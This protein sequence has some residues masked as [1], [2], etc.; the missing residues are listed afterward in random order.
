MR[1]I[2]RAI[3]FLK[4]QSW[5]WKYHFV[6][7]DKNYTFWNKFHTFHKICISILIRRLKYYNNILKK[8][9]RQISRVIIFIKS[10]S[11]IWNYHPVHK[12]KDYIFWNKFHIF[13]KICITI[14][15][16]RLKYNNNISKKISI[17]KYFDFCL[18]LK[19]N[20]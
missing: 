17:T 6:H 19:I 12:N 13:H 7:K 10:Q 5:I 14:L 16:R 18:S 9:H 11:W 1:H 3:I 20:K 2:S 4:S 8:Y 15:I